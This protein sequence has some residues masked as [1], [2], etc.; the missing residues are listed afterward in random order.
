[1]IAT[2]VRRFSQGV[3]RADTKLKEK[4]IFARGAINVESLSRDSLF[5]PLDSPRRLLFSSCRKAQTQLH[6]ATK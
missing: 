3:R 6:G 4:A 1:M 5:F 2:L